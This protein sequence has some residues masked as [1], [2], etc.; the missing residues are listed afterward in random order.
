MTKAV[1]LVKNIYNSNSPIPSL[2][3][4]S[5]VIAPVERADRMGSCGF[6]KPDYVFLS[7]HYHPQPPGKCRR[8]Q[9]ALGSTRWRIL[10]IHM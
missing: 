10:L 3:A 1:L 4:V 2:Q 9:V 7:W 6:F 5:A 8:F